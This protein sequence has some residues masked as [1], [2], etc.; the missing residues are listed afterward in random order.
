MATL[1]NVLLTRNA[2]ALDV[3]D[4]LRN[5]VRQKEVKGRL[6]KSHMGL[7]AVYLYVKTHAS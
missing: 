4:N 1:A 7:V 5:D 6:W 2:G 3:L